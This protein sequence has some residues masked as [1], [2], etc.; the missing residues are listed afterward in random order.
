MPG[1]S[2][3]YVFDGFG[4]TTE[5]LDE[6]G[7]VIESYRYT[8][9]GERITSNS[10]VPPF[11]FQGEYGYYTDVETD[12]YYA[13]KR[14]YSP[15]IARF[16]GADPLGVF[17]AENVYLYT[18]N[19]PTNLFDPSGLCAVCDWKSFWP[20]SP[21]SIAEL[22]KQF[23]LDQTPHLRTMRVWQDEVQS[24][25]DS[26]KSGDKVELFTRPRVY[27]LSNTK[28]GT[29]EFG[30][31]VRGS[32]FFRDAVVC[33]TKD[34]PC[35]VSAIEFVTTYVWEKGRRMWRQVESTRKEI[36]SDAIP[37]KAGTDVDRNLMSAK[38]LAPRVIGKNTCDLVIVLA[39]QPQISNVDTWI[40]KGVITGVQR[41]VTQIIEVRGNDGVVGFSFAEFQDGFSAD[42]GNP[43]WKA[44]VLE[45]Y[46]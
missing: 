10:Y 46:P 28:E 4:N 11:T 35:R 42:K 33:E 5:L 7:D 12:T 6:N 15:M 39:D 19:N 44:K 31:Q 14:N 43:V 38:L 25:A 21:S 18:S 34:D 22:D 20:G 37:N 26:I 32:L 8:A 36:F 9:F 30:Y 24:A 40:D 27:L 23:K 13:R 29:P 45:E 1:S 3:Y 17:V 2:E 41:K 16:L